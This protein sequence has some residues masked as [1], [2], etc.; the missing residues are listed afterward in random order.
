[1][2]DPS[3]KEKADLLLSL[4]DGPDMLVLPNIWDPI[5]ARIL[6]TQGYPAVATA[7]AAVSAAMGYQDGEMV[8]RATMISVIGRIARSVDVPVT[9][10]MEA[11][12]GESLS[13]LELTVNQVIESGVVGLNIQDSIAEGGGLRGVDD[14]CRRIAAVRDTANRRGLPLVINARV[15]SFL[16]AQFKGGQRALNEATSRAKAYAAAGADCIYPIGPGDEATVRALRDRIAAPINVIASATSAPLSKLHEIGVNRVSFGPYVF[17]ACLKKFVDIIVDLQQN[18]DCTCLN[19]TMT[20]AQVREFLLE[21][22][23]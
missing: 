4:H 7:S 8:S 2:S 11:G 23:E 19:E 6:Q 13:E 12:Y 5:G 21:G 14:Q 20:A 15:D 17:R 18:G 9:A 3:Q 16:S 22:R 1:V 10:D